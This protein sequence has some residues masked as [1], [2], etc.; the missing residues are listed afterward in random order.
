MLKLTYSEDNFSLEHLEISLETWVNKRII[1]SLKLG[2]N[3]H[4]QP[5]TA[6]FIIPADLRNIKDL[7]N[8]VITNQIEICPSDTEF[9]E[10]ILKG[11]WLTSKA[12][13][14]TGVFVTKLQPN[15]ELLLKEIQHKKF[16]HT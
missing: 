11:I 12:E 1:L 4:V 15:A 7:E 8:L 6:A 13:S 9:I 2:K 3:I 10:V 14:E 5:S 16:C